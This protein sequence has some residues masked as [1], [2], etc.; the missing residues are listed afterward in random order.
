MRMSGCPYVTRRRFRRDPTDAL[1]TD[2][3]QSIL[4]DLWW[5][6]SR[7]GTGQ[8]RAA[9][10]GWGQV[11]GPVHAP[12]STAGASRTACRLSNTGTTTAFK[13]HMLQR[14]AVRKVL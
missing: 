10:R 14:P 7:L 1:F 2:Q 4:D 3:S 5:L 11:S 13:D 8:Q 9:A 6:L 12:S